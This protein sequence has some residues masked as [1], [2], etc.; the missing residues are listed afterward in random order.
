MSTNNYGIQ[1]NLEL[2]NQSSL[3]K[4]GTILISFTMWILMGFNT[5]NADYLAYNNLYKNISTFGIN[6]DHGIEIGFRVLMYGFSFFSDDYQIFLCFFS[7]ICIFFLIRV[8]RLYTKN[9]SLTLIL[10]LINGF[11]FN[12]IQLR[13]FIAMI[14]ILF[15]IYVLISSDEKKV[16]FY[17]IL[18]ILTATLF[19]NTSL[20]YLVLLSIKLQKRH[21]Y[22]IA[23]MILVITM[24]LS[25]Q[26]QVYFVDTK[27]TVYF[28]GDSTQSGII[29]IL[30]SL[31]FC[32]NLFLVK[33]ISEVGSRISKSN[34]SK[35]IFVINILASASIMLLFLNN[36]FIRITRNINLLNCILYVQFAR[37]V[38]LKTKLKNYLLILI[39]FAY[40]VFSG[41]YFTFRSSSF[42]SAF[43][44]FFKNNVIFDY[45]L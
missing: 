19:H 2:C 39:F 36:N 24:I 42:E 30:M 27:Y 28:D 11:F 45:F 34:L 1:S 25:T 6:A 29:N 8:I 37:D 20:Y 38:Y 35:Y 4:L 40:I 32:V 3:D 5:F 17:Y 7:L 43:L 14:I 31:Y 41:Y 16:Y 13:S 21:I 18:I 9:V 15:G 23:T 22:F 44:V 10:F 26:L 33:K 12:A